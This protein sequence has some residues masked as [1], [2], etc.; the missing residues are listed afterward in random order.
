MKNEI[1]LDLRFK[2]LL[3]TLHPT[4]IS[5]NKIDKEINNL[6]KVLKKTKYLWLK[7]L[8]NLTPKEC[9]KITELRKVG[10]KSSS[11]IGEIV[12]SEEVGSI[13]IF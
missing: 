7:N 6:L 8:S 11:V 1:F 5:N 10:L 2:T 4:T 12:E 3:V 13:K 9:Q